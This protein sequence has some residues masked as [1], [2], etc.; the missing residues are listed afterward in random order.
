MIIIILHC[1]ITTPEQA[2][3]AAAQSEL[4]SA[5]AIR[6]K[7]HEDF[8]AQNT[9]Y[10]ESIDAIERA[11][12]V[13][14]AKKADVAQSLLQVQNMPTIPASA[15]ATIRSFLVL[16]QDSQDQ[17]LVIVIFIVISSS[18]RNSNSN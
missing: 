13:L 17:Q 5:Q 18:H 11:I 10:S 7:E 1:F 14:K 16:A 15:K 6:D 3:T 12:A 2:Q 8:R 9:D 4:D